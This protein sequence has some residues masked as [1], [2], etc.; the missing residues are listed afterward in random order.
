M[1]GKRNN[2]NNGKHFDINT[3]MTAIKMF[4]LFQFGNN[5]RQGFTEL[6]IKDV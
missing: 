5:A 3:V 4:K 2:Y 1:G 6:Q